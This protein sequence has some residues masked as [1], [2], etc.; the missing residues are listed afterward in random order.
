VARNADQRPFDASYLE[1]VSDFADHA[2]IALRL[3]TAREHEQELTILADRERIAH[4]LHDHVIQRLFATGLD[5]QGIIARSHNPDISSRLTRT[6][7]GLQ[8]TIDDIRSA[9]FNLQTAG[10]HDGGFRSRIHSAVADL[11]ENREMATALHFSGPMF[12]VGAELAEHAEAVVI[13]A[14]S[15]A[16]RHSGATRV[17]VEVTVGDEITIDVVD[18]GRGIPEDNQRRSGLANL[19]QRA[20]QQGGRCQ[21]TTPPTGGTHVRWSA[22]LTVA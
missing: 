14:I 5:L 20:E 11:T 10:R 13:E 1:L 18:D 16:V 3:S 7:D 12:A 22:P 2:A 19:H 6:V 21:I 4:D 15:N 9:I 8:S 17:S